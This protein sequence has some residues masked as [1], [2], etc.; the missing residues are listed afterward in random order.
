MRDEAALQSTLSLVIGRLEDFA[1]RVHDKMPEVDWL[2]QRE[3]IRTLVKR[4]EIN[5][6][7]VNVVFRADATLPTP[8]LTSPGQ[9]SLWQDCGKVGRAPLRRTAQGLAIP[10]V[11]HVAG[12]E[13]VGY[14]AQPS[15]VLDVLR[16]RLQQD[17]MVDIVERGPQLIPL[18]RTR[19]LGM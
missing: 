2:M 15:V 17:V 1:K 16:Q 12:L 6:D 11:L 4:V 14:E 13:H 18:S 3:L 9:N 5:Q 10:P 19:R 8:D 7:D